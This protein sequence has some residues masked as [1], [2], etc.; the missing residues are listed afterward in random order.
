VAKSQSADGVAAT[1]SPPLANAPDVVQKYDFPSSR[2]IPPVS[3]VAPEGSPPR[4]ATTSE[5]TDVIP[6]PLPSRTAP[7][8]S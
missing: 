7:Q 4:E 8:A 3:V 1:A 6:Q 2:S 5:S